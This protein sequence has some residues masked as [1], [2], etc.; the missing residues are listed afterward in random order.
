LNILL[1]FYTY[2]LA[3]LN[4]QTPMKAK[5]LVLIKCHSE[6]KKHGKPVSTDRTWLTTHFI[7]E[8]RPGVVV[9]VVVVAAVCFSRV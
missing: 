2:F 4:V 5:S 8:L 9:V 1:S 7:L 3:I 6:Y